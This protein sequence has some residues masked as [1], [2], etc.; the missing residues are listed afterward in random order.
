M[1]HHHSLNLSP[2]YSRSSPLYIP[3]PCSS[4]VGS[5]LQIHYNSHSTH[6]PL[7]LHSSPSW[8]YLIFHLL[9]CYSRAPRS[10]VPQACHTHHHSYHLHHISPPSPPP[11]S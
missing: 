8:L 2:L 5:S 9:Y 3:Y 10:L 11:H 1:L 4:P 6:L 7:P